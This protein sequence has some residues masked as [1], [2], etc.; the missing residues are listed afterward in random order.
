[1][2]AL[3]SRCPNDPLVTATIPEAGRDHAAAADGLTVCPP[4]ANAGCA[5]SE[6]VHPGWL[7]PL[8]RSAS[9][10]GGTERRTPALQCPPRPCF[11]VRLAT[12]A[13]R[14][15]PVG[16]AWAFRVDIK[17]RLG[18]YVTVDT[19]SVASGAVQPELCRIWC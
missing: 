9:W 13:H 7:A 18:A 3:L 8:L 14:V 16:G 6:R 15:W 19:G 2:R 5:G 17:S 10:W 1:V 12:P 11:G 4:G